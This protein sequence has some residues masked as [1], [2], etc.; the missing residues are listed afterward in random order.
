MIFHSIILTTNTLSQDNIP[1]LKGS[2]DSEIPPRPALSLG[3][4]DAFPTAMVY[5]GLRRPP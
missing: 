2:E 3:H 5:F 1:H 4:L